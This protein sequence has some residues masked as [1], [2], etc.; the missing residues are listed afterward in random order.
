MTLLQRILQDVRN[1]LNRVENKLPTV[2]TEAAA[3]GL[4]Y[5]KQAEALLASEPVVDITTL[6]PTTEPLRE[7]I[8]VILKELEI[9]FKAVQGSFQ[10][11]TSY[12]AAG[13]IAQLKTGNDVPM[14]V[15][16]TGVQAEWTKIQIGLLTS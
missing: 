7:E 5:T 8:L 14:S 10:H 3:F 12:I 13:R 4:S 11:G 9:A 15:I 2:I 16:L 6:V 1:F